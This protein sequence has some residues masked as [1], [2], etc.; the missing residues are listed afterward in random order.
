MTGPSESRRSQEPVLPTSQGTAPSQETSSF[1]GWIK[2]G[3]G[4]LT[5]TPILFTI[6]GVVGLGIIWYATFQ[7]IELEREN[8]RQAARTSTRELTE[9][10]EAQVV[11]AL[12]GIDKTFRF[13][14]VTYQAEGSLETAFERLQDEQLLPP[15]LIFNIQITD[16]QGTVV[17]GTHASQGT[18]IAQQAIWQKS[19][20]ADSLVIAAPEKVEGEWKIT[21][22]RQLTTAT[23]EVRGVAVVRA[24]SSFFVS[25]YE[26]NKLGQKGALGLLGQD[27][28]FRAL[29]VGQEVMAGTQ[30][31]HQ[32]F[33]TGAQ[34]EGGE[35]IPVYTLKNG[36]D[37][38]R[39]FVGVRPLFGF[40]LVVVVGQA[41]T[42]VLAPVRARA[43]RYMMR[44][45]VGSIAFFLFLLAL[46][47]TRWKLEQIREREQE[48]QVA[49]ARYVEHMAYHDSLT[50]LPNRSFFSKLLGD[51]IQKARRYGR[52]FAVLFMDLDRF[53]RIN[54][55]LGHDTGDELLE[56]VGERLKNT[57]RKSDTVAR[58]GGDEFVV[59]VPELDKRAEAATVAQK[60][61]ASMAQPFKLM[62]QEFTVTASIGISLYPQDG[63]DE[64]TLMKHADLAMYRAKDEG[65]N[66]F[67][68]YS[69]ELE[70]ISR[71]RLTLETEL[72]EALRKEEFELHYQPRRK[73][74][75]EQITGVEALLR[76]KHPTKGL[77]KPE[78]FLDVAEETGLIVPIGRWA[79]KKACRQAVSWQEQGVPGFRMAVNLSGRQFFD[80]QLLDNVQDAL[81]ESGLAAQ[82]LELEIAEGALVQD[83]S[84]AIEKFRALQQLGVHITLDNF[85]SRYAMLSQLQP[86]GIDAVKVDQRILDEADTRHLSKETSKAVLTLSE[87]FS[88]T[89]IGQGVES[90][91]EMNSLRDQAYQEVQGFYFHPPVAAEE[92]VRILKRQKPP[93]PEQ[94]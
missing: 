77:L 27:G 4:H 50:G 30:I 73:V 3:L 8:A 59:L 37:G 15:N 54:D 89:I 78:K 67:R 22:G 91:E 9:T 74:S 57:L 12:Q 23:G 14:Q 20:K 62:E 76:W 92:C 85:G 72:R 18:N 28:V 7:L 65:R 56:Q 66:D 47:W 61:L 88:S 35:E 39:R 41:E 75:S 10:Y 48:A 21:L 87:Q 1:W 24:S 53:K 69:G 94:R 49:H 63:E 52:K 58:M 68:F 42:E 29:R 93:P 46:G 13:L 33:L 2:Q 82:Q 71:Q 90:D 34:G 40:P 19:R 80:L 38:V 55:T 81:Q 6:I 32:Q 36:W 70:T 25:G 16:R 60:I 17:A 44:A 11:R 83:P 43:S 51:R 79:L 64:Q 5:D 26:A 84:R 86:L 45:S 31:T